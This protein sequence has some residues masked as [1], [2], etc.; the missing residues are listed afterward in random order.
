MNLPRG[1]VVAIAAVAVVVGGAFTVDSVSASRSEAD[2]SSRIRPSTDG[3]GPVSVRIG[4]GPTARWSGP[5]TLAG[6]T[7]RAEGVERPG[8]GP[9]AVEAEATDVYLPPD[10]TDAVTSG[11]VEVTVQIT[12]DSLAPA[13]GMRDVLLGA[14]DDP[15]LA[16]GIERRARITG[17]LEAT[18]DRVSAIVDLVV[19]DRG[20]H[21]VPVAA[22]TGPGGIPDQDP[23]LALRAT[24][25]TFSPDLLPLGAAVDDLTV[26]GGT[27]TATG[28]AGPGTTPLRDLV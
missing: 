4:G 26:K 18:G 11:D 3:V 24:A 19:D 10:G 27:I 1:A 28:T 14:A 12:G 5:D 9:V 15:S 16:G 2:L 13:L 21:L 22:A 20:A 25:L 8:L 6:V 23:A 17:T 7:M